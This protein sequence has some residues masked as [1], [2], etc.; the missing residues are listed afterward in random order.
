MK[1]K[2][3]ITFGR[4]LSEMPEEITDTNPSPKSL[5]ENDIPVLISGDG[6][7]VV[8]KSGYVMFAVGLL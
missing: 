5:R 2:Q 3:T 6:M 7:A 4:L 8:Y 1:E